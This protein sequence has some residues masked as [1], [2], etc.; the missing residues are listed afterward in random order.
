M[1]ITN[2]LYL[3]YLMIAFLIL[4]KLLNINGSNTRKITNIKTQKFLKNGLYI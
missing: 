2:K 4:M 1:R 3:K